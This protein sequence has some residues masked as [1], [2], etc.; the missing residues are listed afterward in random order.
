MTGTARTLLTLM[1]RPLL[2]MMSPD[3]SSGFMVR[4][5]EVESKT[6]SEHLPAPLPPLL[7]EVQIPATTVN[8]YEQ[9][10]VIGPITATGQLS[11]TI[12][13]PADCRKDEYFDIYLRNWNKCNPYPADPPVFTHI[14]ILVVAAPA[15]PVAPDVNVCDG[16]AATLVAVHGN[17][18]GTVLRWYADAAKTT[19]LANGSAYNVGI[20]AVGTYKYYVADEGTISGNLCEGPVKE[21]TLKVNPAITNNTISGIQTLC[22]G[23]TPTALTGTPPGGGDLSYVFQWESSTG[24][25]G[26]P[27]TSIS[28]ANSQG[29]SPPALTNT[30]WYRRIVTSGGCSS[31]SNVIEKTVTPTVGTP[32]FT[33][34]ATTVCQD[35]ANETYTAT[36]TNTTGITYTASPAGAGVI[37]SST[38]VMN[39]NAAFTGAATITASA[40][41]CNGPRTANRS[42]TVTPTVGTPAFTAGATTVCQDAANETYTATATNTTGITYSASPAGAGVINSSTGVMNWNAAFSGDSHNNGQCSRM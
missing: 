39:W 26:G 9:L 1:A 16:V 25:A 42:V 29:Y 38:G 17:P 40:A 41:G 3:I 13:I 19:W 27:F 14:R 35:A 24:G 21:V 31:T 20:K 28:G 30:T 34:G 8:G 7:S 33:A 4:T 23:S 6:P 32:T 18:A 10:P 36:A 2:Q 15:P 37:N 22:S 11:Q 12:L 5:M